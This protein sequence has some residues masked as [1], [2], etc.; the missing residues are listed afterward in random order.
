[1]VVFSFPQKRNIAV[2]C[3]DD[4]PNALL[5]RRMVLEKAASTC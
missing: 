5:I 3:V 2:L 4:E 1:M